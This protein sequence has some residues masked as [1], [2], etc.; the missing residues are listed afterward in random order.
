MCSVSSKLKLEYIDHP[1]HYYHSVNT[2]LDIPTFMVEVT[3][4]AQEP[5]PA[6]VKYVWKI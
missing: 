5:I 4:Y 2:A 1:C 3:I 6:C